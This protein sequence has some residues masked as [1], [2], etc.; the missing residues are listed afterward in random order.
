L[1]DEYILP[2][3]RFAGAILQGLMTPAE[4]WPYF[5]NL[6][7]DQSVA[8]G[9][10]ALN[11]ALLGPTGIITQGNSAVVLGISQSAVIQT[12]EIRALLALPTGQQ[13][14]ASQLS[15]IIL[16]NPNNPNGGLFAR[17][18]GFYVP[19]LDVAFNGATPQ[20][21]WHT[22]I[23]TNQYDG[24][25]DFPQYPLNLVSDLNAA[26]G[27]FNGTHSYFNS[28]AGAIQLPTSPGFTGNTTYFETLTQNLPLV[29][30]FRQIPF[31]GNA[32]AD[33]LQPDLRVIVDLGYA[34]YGP[35]G[36]FANIPTPATLVS[37][38]NP[39]VVIPDLATGAVQGI[40]AAGVDLGLLPA[41]DLPTTY[42]FVPSLDP[43]L[44]FFLGQPSTT[45]LSIAAGALGDVL[46]L[47]P[48][49]MLG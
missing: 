32:I 14:S 11:N 23:Y 30:P 16:G 4:F 33:L 38:P 3:P 5:G 8:G 37:I 31:V 28:A 1:F 42:P 26:I 48:P 27:F 49:P 34:G 21:P 40:Q 43:Q 10:A 45:A 44:H 47:I 12:E 29:G 24:A 35:G 17:F 6:T 22:D 9:V 46:R 15:F 13:P 2:N 39:F 25:A 7:L 20:S 41:S 19:I 36:N 18:P